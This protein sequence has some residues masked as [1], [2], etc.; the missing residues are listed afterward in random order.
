MHSFPTYRAIHID[1]TI[2]FGLALLLAT[3][4]AP[5][6]LNLGYLTYLITLTNI[7]AVFAI[8]WNL[9]SGYVGL[10]S[11]GQSF[12]FGI[13]GYSYALAV[14][15]LDLPFP[16]ALVIGAAVGSAS[17]VAIM[18]P[19]LRLKGHFFALLT[20]LVPLVAERVTAA[21]P[22]LGGHD[23]IFG[24]P[25]MS[26]DPWIMFHLSFVL[27][28]FAVLVSQLVDKT[29]LGLT[30]RAIRADETAAM[31]AGINVP[32]TKM[33]LMTISGFVAGLAGGFYASLIGVESPTIYELEKA[34]LPLIMTVIGG[35]G[36][37]AGPIIGAY[38][39]QGVIEG[40]RFEAIARIRLLIYAVVAFLLY[41]FFPSGLVG[42][43]RRVRDMLR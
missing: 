12:F 8:S 29:R 27:L 14:L 35:Q 5:V 2:I 41:Y 23:G 1:K 42:L 13:A 36:T 32:R 37:V 34:S 11:L 31:A 18:L 43:A 30:A 26:K 10:L 4:L 9:L 15:N 16:V 25:A 17:G 3:W 19:S 39:I 33:L 24:I 40:L 20:L 22:Q 38:L 7:F 28:V 6:F 21:I